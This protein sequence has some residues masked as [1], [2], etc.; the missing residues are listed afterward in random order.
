VKNKSWGGIIMCDFCENG[1]CLEC[2]IQSR[3]AIEM[4]KD[5]VDALLS[6]IEVCNTFVLAAAKALENN[7]EDPAGI[8]CETTGLLV[9][10]SFVDQTISQLLEYI[11]AVEGCCGTDD[12]CRGCPYAED[13]NTTDEC[14]FD[15]PDFFVLKENL[16][17]TE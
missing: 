1:T 2:L 3:S 7:S 8:I 12:F 5:F 15:D 11:D 13:C 17:A 16:E 6:R 4:S 9:E 14:F 10:L